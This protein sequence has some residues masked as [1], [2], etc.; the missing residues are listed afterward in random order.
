MEQVNQA[1]GSLRRNT[2]EAV[3]PR[4][5]SAALSQAVEC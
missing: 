5:E 1:A 3:P 4:P 2:S